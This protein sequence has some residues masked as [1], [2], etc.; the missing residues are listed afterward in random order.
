MAST[1][2][3]PNNLNVTRNVAR[4]GVARRR[5]SGGKLKNKT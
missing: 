1:W 5:Q 3:P 2:L 4:I